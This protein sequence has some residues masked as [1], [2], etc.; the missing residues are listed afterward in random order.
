MF[1]FYRYNNCLRETLKF[2]NW[3]YAEDRLLWQF[4]LRHGERRIWATVSAKLPGRT[5]N[6]CYQRYKV[7]RK[8]EDEN[9]ILANIPVCFFP[10]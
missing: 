6:S 8:W 2:G 10:W 7:L 5:Q 4:I 9:N 1:T 3:T